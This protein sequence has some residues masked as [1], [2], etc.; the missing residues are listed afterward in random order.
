[1]QI[2]SCKKRKWSLTSAILDPPHVGALINRGCESFSAAKP[3]KGKIKPEH[4]PK[5]NKSSATHGCRNI[6]AALPVTHSKNTIF[7]CLRVERGCAG[8]AGWT[9]ADGALSDHQGCFWVLISGFCLCLNVLQPK[10]GQTLFSCQRRQC[11]GVAVDGTSHNG[12][13]L[14]CAVVVIWWVL[15]FCLLQ[16][17]DKIQRIF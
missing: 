13:F 12:L 9:Q 1:M 10:R 11:T 8:D 16:P 5:L 2:I 3:K 14:I 15:Y 6:F 4:F 7:S 17:R